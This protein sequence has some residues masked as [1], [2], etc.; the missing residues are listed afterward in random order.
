MLEE[1]KP[2]LEKHNL[3]KKI[4]PVS[5]IVT[6]DDSLQGCPMVADQFVKLVGKYLV[7]F[8]VN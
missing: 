7:E 4:E 2:F 5:A 3:R 6:V 8:K 1:I